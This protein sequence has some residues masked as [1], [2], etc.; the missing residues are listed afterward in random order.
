MI[1]LG[2]YVVI[3]QPGMYSGFS[4]KNSSCRNHRNAAHTHT[5]SSDPIQVYIAC[6]PAVSTCPMPPH[7]S[8]G[9]RSNN[10][11]STQSSNF[12]SILLANRHILCGRVV[13]LDSS[14]HSS[15]TAELAGRCRKAHQ[16]DFLASQAGVSLQPSNS[17][18]SLFFSY[19]FVFKI[20]AFAACV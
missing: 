10:F 1:C 18:S 17:V 12:A 5:H 6:I 14:P 9:R 13:N 16:G 20:L 4:V 11:P 2:H 15:K 19:S 8:L 3:V 7:H